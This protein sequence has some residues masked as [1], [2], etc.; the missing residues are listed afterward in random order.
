MQDYIEDLLEANQT[1][2]CDGMLD[3]VSVIDDLFD[4]QSIEFSLNCPTIQRLN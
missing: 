1:E 4:K 2:C 3:T